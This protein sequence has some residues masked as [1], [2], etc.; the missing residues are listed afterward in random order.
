MNHGQM[1]L[2]G[3]KIKNVCRVT[4]LQRDGQADRKAATP[5]GEEEA[6]R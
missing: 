1:W 2:A 4:V 6:D 5:A 3:V